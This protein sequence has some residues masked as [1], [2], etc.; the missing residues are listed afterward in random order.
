MKQ[1]NTSY[2]CIKWIAFYHQSSW[3]QENHTNHQTSTWFILR[4]QKKESEEQKPDSIQFHFQHILI[5]QEKHNTARGLKINIFWKQPQ[6]IGM[7][8]KRELKQQYFTNF[9]TDGF[10]N[11]HPHHHRCS[12]LLTISNKWT[13]FT[14]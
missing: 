7:E 4:H 14:Q 2:V 11:S 6:Q 3:T 10:Q 5:N 12:N 8:P 1:L 9:H 13:D